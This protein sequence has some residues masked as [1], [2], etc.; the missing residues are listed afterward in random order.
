MPGSRR[1][2]AGLANEQSGD[3]DSESNESQR[4]A[5]IPEESLASEHCD[6]ADHESRFEKNFAEIKIVC[7]AP[8]GLPLRLPAFSLRPE[9]P[10]LLPCTARFPFRTSL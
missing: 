1:T 6:R 2:D 4:R 8:L 7:V 10:G 3:A 9:Y 5:E